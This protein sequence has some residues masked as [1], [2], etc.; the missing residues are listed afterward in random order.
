MKGDYVG[1]T[2]K[3]VE[4]RVLED[5][6]PDL[7]HSRETLRVEYGDLTTILNENAR[8]RA[9]VNQLQA[10][11]TL[12][13]LS[14]RDLKEVDKARPG[15]ADRMMRFSRIMAAKLRVNAHKGTWTK[16]SLEDLLRMLGDEVNELAHEVERFGDQR[17]KPID[18]AR[19]C[20]DVA[21]FAMFIADVCGGLD[22]DPPMDG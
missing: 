16:T 22:V 18:I 1:E 6:D 12:T 19:E 13:V 7:M 21:N 10:H 17:C 14:N 4:A 15:V 3:E 20:G 9:Q 8:L 11:G 2:A 5:V